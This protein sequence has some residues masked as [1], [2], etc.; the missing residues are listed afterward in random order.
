MWLPLASVLITP[1]AIL[2][3]QCLCVVVGQY[4]TPIQKYYSFLLN[5]T[6]IQ[7]YYSRIPD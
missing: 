6:L 1:G 7:K 3:G 5:L 4:L 2:I